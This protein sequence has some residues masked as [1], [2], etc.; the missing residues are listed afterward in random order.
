LYDKD[1]GK[2]SLYY[3]NIIEHL[4]DKYNLKINSILDITC[5]TGDLVYELSIEYDAM[6]S[7]ISPHMI[8]TARKNIRQLNSI[9]LAWLS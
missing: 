9:S 3:V 2:F 8:N 1:W 6:G 4:K 5:G 7:D